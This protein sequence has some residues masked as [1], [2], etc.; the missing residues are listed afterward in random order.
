MDTVKLNFTF[1]RIRN[2]TVKLNFTF[3]EL[4]NGYS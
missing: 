1:L 4:R 3:Y 2:V